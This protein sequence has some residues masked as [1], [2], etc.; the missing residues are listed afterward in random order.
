MT[1]EAVSRN[2]ARMAMERLPPPS[3]LD[4]CNK[5]GAALADGWRKWREEFTLYC[6]LALSEAEE[7]DQIKMFKYLVG[8]EGREIYNT[9]R[10]EKEE[11]HRTMKIVLETFDRHCEP[12]KNEIVER[13][14]LNVRQ[15][16]DETFETF[17]TDI[18]IL[19]KTCNYGDLEM[20]I[21]R[22]KIVVG[23]KDTHLRERLLRTKDLDLQTAEDMCRASEITKQSAITLDQATAVHKV[24]EAPKKSTTGPK[25]QK[26]GQCK[27]C[28]TIHEFVK[29][30]CPAYG[31]TCRKCNGRNHFETK[32][33]TKIS[34]PK[35]RQ[36]RSLPPRGR[37][38][39]YVNEE[40]EDEVEE[41]FLMV[42]QEHK[43]L[44]IT[45]LP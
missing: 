25:H 44:S 11:K 7:I 17:L 38:V 21:L 29:E 19:A 37:Q 20:S 15:Q 12:Q 28:G 36:Q 24:N 1:E 32:C 10:W 35:G 42:V 40:E 6:D 3:K 31:Q 43:R 23:I 5:T 8:P 39:R 34:T 2:F 26:N 14:K 16:G 45:G 33:Y 18:K 13:F 22:D 27:F 9:Q 30:K 41:D 4:F